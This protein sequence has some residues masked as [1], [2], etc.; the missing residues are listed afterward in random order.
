MNGQMYSSM[1]EPT[2][3]WSKRHLSIHPSIQETFTEHLLSISHRRYLASK[4][5]FKEIVVQT[6]GLAMQS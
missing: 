5:A 2:D 4:I 3:E 6:D 1:N